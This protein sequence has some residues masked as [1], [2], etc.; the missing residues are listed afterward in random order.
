MHPL[1]SERKKQVATFFDEF[2][3]FDSGDEEV[4]E[5]PSLNKASSA[6]PKLQSSMIEKTVPAKFFDP[7]KLNRAISM[8]IPKSRFIRLSKSIQERLPSE[9]L[10]LD[11]IEDR[12]SQTSDVPKFARRTVTK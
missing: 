10:E 12:K 9:Y 7:K 8:T 5:E 2:K 6:Q 3:N 11:S 1:K 4:K